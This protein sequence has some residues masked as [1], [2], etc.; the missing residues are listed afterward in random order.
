M[1]PVSCT[2]THHDV[3]DLINLEGL[4]I[5]K[6][7]YLENGPQLFFETKNFLTCASDGVF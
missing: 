1:Q 4:K 7:K 5:K 2:N 6:I 3:R